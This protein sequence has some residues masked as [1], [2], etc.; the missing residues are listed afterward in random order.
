VP[1]GNVGSG[2]TLASTTSGFTRHNASNKLSGPILSGK[3][4]ELST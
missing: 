1:T 4:S 3:S 2:F